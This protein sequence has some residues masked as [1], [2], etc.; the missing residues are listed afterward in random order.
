MKKAVVIASLLV[1]LANL[2][3]QAQS[4]LRNQNSR[5][6]RDSTTSGSMN[7]PNNLPQTSTIPSDSSTSTPTSNRNTNRRNRT[8]PNQAHTRQ[9]DTT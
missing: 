8:A 5:P 7:N 3:S 1:G 4:T 9:R 6:N 2:E